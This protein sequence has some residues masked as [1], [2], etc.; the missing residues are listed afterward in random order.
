MSI[1]NVA[2]GDALDIVGARAVTLIAL[3]SRKP[4]R[5]HAVDPL[6]DGENVAEVAAALAETAAELVRLTDGAGMD[7]LLVTG[8]AWFHLLRVVDGGWVAHLMLDRRVANLALARR[9]FR[10]LVNSAT[11]QERSRSPAL[12]RR[13]PAANLP[14]PAS[15]PVEPSNWFATVAGEPYRTDART[16]RR[17]RDGLRQLDGG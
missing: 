6:P 17:V 2:W 5:S 10:A 14:R 15:G 7:D 13:T 4:L 9:E 1:E 11:V 16:L 3:D 12:P 8:P